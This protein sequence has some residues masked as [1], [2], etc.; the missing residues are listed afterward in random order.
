MIMS[1][2]E[3]W[4]KDAV[5]REDAEERVTADAI[6]A[7][8][9]FELSRLP[10]RI[11]E[12][13]LNYIRWGAGWRVLDSPA[14]AI[15]EILM[16]PKSR[17]TP[18]QKAYAWLRFVCNHDGIRGVQNYLA[19]L[20]ELKFPGYEDF[21]NLDSRCFIDYTPSGYA[22]P[23]RPKFRTNV[24]P[25]LC[26][27][28][29]TGV[30][31]EFLK[32]I[33]QKSPKFTARQMFLYACAN[34]RSVDRFA[35]IL[36]HI[37]PQ[38]GRANFVDALGYS[39][40]FYTVFRDDSIFMPEVERSNKLSY[41]QK[42][43]FLGLIKAAGA[44]PDRKCR[45]GFSWEDL[46]SVAEELRE[47]DAGKTGEGLG[48]SERDEV[49]MGF[50]QTRGPRPGSKPF[51]TASDEIKSLLV[52]DSLWD[53][54][55]GFAAI[56]HL[57]Y[58]PESLKKPFGPRERFVSEMI[59]DVKSYKPAVR[60]KLLWM[61]CNEETFAGIP[62]SESRG[63]IPE[64][65][66]DCPNARKWYCERK[67]K[68]YEDI[69][70]SDTFFFNR[71][72]PFKANSKIDEMVERGIDADSPAQFMMALSVGGKGVQQKYFFEVLRRRKMKILTYLWE[73]DDTIKKLLDPRRMLFYACANWSGEDAVGCVNRIE[74]EHP[75]IVKSCVDV[76]GRNLLWYSLY[77]AG[78]KEDAS[79]AKALIRHG[80]DPDAPTK[81][82]MSW[83]DMVAPV[84]PEHYPNDG[85]EYDVY[86]NGEKMTQDEELP[87]GYEV[88]Q[89]RLGQQR[90]LDH[91]KVMVVI[92]KSGIEQEWEYDGLLLSDG[93]QGVRIMPGEFHVGY[94]NCVDRYNDS[95]W[96]RFRQLS[97]GLFHIVDD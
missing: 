4:L 53:L 43:E 11:S 82:G 33:T 94:S 56:C 41:A 39:P 77:H 10:Y 64:G 74:A 6:K 87:W 16:A 71:A 29:S 25:F 66:L 45:Y 96:T 23:E 60:R 8:H 22:K 85:F 92:R 89:P 47:Q 31:V 58:V 61:V 51:P 18:R 65:F 32:A 35:Y 81:W 83:R 90:T 9:P 80:C 14:Y 49:I 78:L 3:S 75:G 62:M 70:C 37:K 44:R 13:A 50:R 73:N 88:P 84:G 63:N 5:K 76:F 20:V 54:R 28:E 1:D 95:C 52:S 72:I 19:V 86:I 24:E 97:D 17:F 48:T 15:G 93:Y 55:R 46:E 69:Q 42:K 7:L 26:G 38:L 21:Q 91:L 57:P 59:M 67:L 79:L 68:G 36:K 34:C 12:D 40:F 2:L 27:E 30:T